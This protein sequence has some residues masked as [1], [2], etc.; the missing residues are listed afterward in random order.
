MTDTASQTVETQGR[1]GKSAG[2]VVTAVV[3]ILLGLMFLVF[4][5]N[6]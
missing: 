2:R 5:L 4:G 3:R 6:G 1:E